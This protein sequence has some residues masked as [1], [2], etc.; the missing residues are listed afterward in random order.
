MA[1]LFVAGGVLGSQIGARAAKHLSQRRGALTKVFAGLIVLVAV[2][3]L[4]R[5]LHVIG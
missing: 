2:Y 5:S 4:A 3:M 1:G